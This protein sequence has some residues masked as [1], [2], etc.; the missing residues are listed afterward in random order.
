MAVN[1]KA[2]SQQDRIHIPNE[3]LHFSA[4][5]SRDVMRKLFEKEAHIMRTG[6]ATMRSGSASYTHFRN[7]QFQNAKEKERIFRSA[8]QALEMVETSRHLKSR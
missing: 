6:V 2:R 3:Q 1:E 4:R 5:S 8:N 7:S